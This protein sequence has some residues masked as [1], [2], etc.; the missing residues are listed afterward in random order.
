MRVIGTGHIGRELVEEA[1]GIFPS[2]LFVLIKETG[3][4]ALYIYLT[5]WNVKN[6]GNRYFRNLCYRVE[7]CQKRLPESLSH[8]DP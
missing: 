3:K 7:A 6:Y 1:L 8:D 2:L 4:D 5:H